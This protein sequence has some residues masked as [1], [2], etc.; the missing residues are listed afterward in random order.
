MELYNITCIRNLSLCFLSAQKRASSSGSQENFRHS[1][2]N[3]FGAGFGKSGVKDAEGLVVSSSFKA[4]VSRLV[5]A[6]KELKSQENLV[7]VVCIY[8]KNSCLC[9]ILYILYYY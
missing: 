8:L 3:N 2:A 1:Y 7:S 5:F 4:V 9:S 6:R